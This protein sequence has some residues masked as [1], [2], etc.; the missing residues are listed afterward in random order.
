M[1]QLNLVSFITCQSFPRTSFASS[2]FAETEIAVGSVKC[3][4]SLRE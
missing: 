1:M 3:V 2:E 4:V